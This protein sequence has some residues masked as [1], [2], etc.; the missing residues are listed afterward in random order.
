[1]TNQKR[2]FSQ[3]YRCTPL[4]IAL[5]AAMTGLTGCAAMAPIAN[6]EPIARGGGYQPQYRSEDALARQSNSTP[7]AHSRCVND[8]A[9]GLFPVSSTM[10]APDVEVLTSGDL[11]DVRIGQDETFSGAYKVSQDGTLRLP[12]MPPVR[13]EGLSVEAVEASIAER[14]VA[15]SFYRG[16]PDVSVR[17]TDTAGARVFVSGAV[18][19]PGSMVI[20]GVGGKDVD[21]ARQR[22]I[23]WIA[24]GRRLSRA[25][26]SA[27]GV[28]PDAD[29]S[30]VVVLRGANRMV[31]DVRPA[32]TGQPYADIVLLAGDRIEVASRNCFQDALMVP[33]AITAPGMKVYMSNLTQPASNNASSAIGKE[34]QDLRYGTR[35]MQAMVG[36]NCVGGARLTNADRSVVLLTHNPITGASIV[37]SRRIE[38]LV[39]RADRDD[40]N[41]YI[42]PGDAMACYDSR[43]TNI[44]AIT[45]AFGSVIS[46]ALLASKL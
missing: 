39:R 14:L 23:G 44:L 11:L 20:G 7:L 13:A 25:L 35:L 28:R 29:L 5:A 4:R 34:T 33:S 42:F 19:E 22:A 21:S 15:A 45:N 37:I 31:L 8:A 1:M 9:P 16:A 43:Q 40:F 10:A 27:G 12:H 30:Q 2:Q 36:M 41:P 24:E 46:N 26:Q 32:L 6:L 17:V 3:L 18:F 38:D